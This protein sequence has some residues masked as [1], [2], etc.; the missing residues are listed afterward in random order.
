MH[1]LTAPVVVCV[2][3]LSTAATMNMKCTSNPVMNGL[4][5]GLSSRPSLLARRSIGIRMRKTL[6]IRAIVQEQTPQQAGTKEAE[7]QLEALKAISLV[8]ADTGEIDS[9]RKYGRYSMSAS[10]VASLRRPSRPSASQVQARRLHHQSQSGA[11]SCAEPSVPPLF[12]RGYGLRARPPRLSKQ[13]Q[14]PCC[15]ITRPQ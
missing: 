7:N 3:S 9:I 1:S 15:L 11:Q 13:R 4:A 8:V 14:V 6:A 2:I 10:S 5:P 12:E